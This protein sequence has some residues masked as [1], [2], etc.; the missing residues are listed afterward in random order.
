LESTSGMKGVVGSI[1]GSIRGK[2]GGFGW[3]VWDFETC[4]CC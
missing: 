2:R 4:F 3:T 1:G